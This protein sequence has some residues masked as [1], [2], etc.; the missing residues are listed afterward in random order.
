MTTPFFNPRDFGAKG[1]GQH[2]D[3]AA[4]QQA[5]DA[6]H[7]VGGGQVLLSAG[8]YLTG[9]IVLKS[10]VTLVLLEGCELLA[11]DSE[12]DYLRARFY[13]GIPRYS[14]EKTAL[15]YARHAVHCGVEGRGTINGRDLLFWDELGDKE[16]RDARV[17]YKTKPWR[18]FTIAFDRCQNVHLQNIHI[19]DSSAYAGWI[20]ECDNVRVQDVTVQHHFHGPN[21]DGFHFSSCHKVFVSGCLFHAG[22]DCIAVDGNGPAGSSDV[23]ITNC[24]F[25][26]LTN[27]V[28][29]YTNLDPVADYDAEIPWGT[30]QNVSIS[31][32]TVRN[33]AGV[34]NIV[35]NNG[36]I[37]RV[38]VSGLTVAQELPGTV[39]FLLTQNG[40]INDVDFSHILATGNGAG[41]FMGDRPGSIDRLSLSH[42]SFGIHPRQKQWALGLPEEIGMYTIYHQAPWTLHFRHT[43][44]LRLQHI[45]MQWNGQD[46][47]ISQ[48]PLL[49]CQH[50]RRAK[51]LFSVADSMSGEYRNGSS[52]LK[53]EVLV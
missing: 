2:L 25:E 39:L 46:S 30:V 45:D 7:A 20:V 5:V 24:V 38:Q 17:H 44:G 1:D 18:P 53:A 4:I 48:P 9:T 40:F 51:E 42:C 6:C 27:A 50:T 28:R 8:T 52:H 29:L 13:E 43:H 14:K 36:C 49:V 16:N 11:S 23:V 3:R 35:A 37:S 41:A 34:I 22:D 21:T 10:H 32:C 31:N 33:S 19:V 15:I 12:Q 26:T 47:E